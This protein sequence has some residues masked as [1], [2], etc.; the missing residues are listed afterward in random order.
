MIPLKFY[1]DDEYVYYNN[2]NG[3]TKKMT[4]AEFESM[5]S[6]ESGLPAYSS[7]ND[8][9]VLSVDSDGDLEWVA[10]QPSGGF[11]VYNVTL[12][13]NEV[14]IENANELLTE[15]LTNKKVILVAT[16]NPN[17]VYYLSYVL[18]NNNV[19]AECS[20]MYQSIFNNTI[21]FQHIDY[22]D[23]TWTVADVIK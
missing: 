6:G 20:F 1:R 2:P 3:I 10:L 15:L 23:N 18:I 4:I 16:G 17:S 5:M 14:D 8:G 11:S 7:S 12:G 13:E 19:V 21:D 9:E 22:K